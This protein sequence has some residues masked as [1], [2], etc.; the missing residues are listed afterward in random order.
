MLTRLG[1]WLVLKIWLAVFFIGIILLLI[2]PVLLVGISL[3]ILITVLEFF[4]KICFQ[5][6]IK[7]LKFR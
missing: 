3:A 7:T 2:F 1:F 5:T 6:I 4:A